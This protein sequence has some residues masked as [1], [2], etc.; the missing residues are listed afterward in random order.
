M[1]SF[2][3]KPRIALH[4]DFVV[5]LQVWCF[6]DR[7]K[8]SLFNGRHSQMVGHQFIIWK[9][10]ARNGMEIKEIGKRGRR[11]LFSKPHPQAQI[12]LDI[13]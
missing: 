4:Y 6:T 3:S 2:H 11:S 13:Y 5:L 10:V 9:L 12:S 7:S 8:Y 1:T